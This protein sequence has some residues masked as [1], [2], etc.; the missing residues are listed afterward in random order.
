MQ[1]TA[2]LEELCRAVCSLC[3]KGVDLRYRPETSEYVHDMVTGVTR[4]HSICWANG[5]RKKYQRG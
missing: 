1:I 2:D 5:L 4:L 3:A